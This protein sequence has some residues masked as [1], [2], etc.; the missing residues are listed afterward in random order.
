[1]SEGAPLAPTDF[2]IRFRVTMPLP[3]WPEQFVIMTAYATT[4][5]L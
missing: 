1:M 5:Q 4:G 3:A 2:G